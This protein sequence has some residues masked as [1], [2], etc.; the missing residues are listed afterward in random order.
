MC[1]IIA[2]K[3]DKKASEILLKGIKKLEYRG[4]DS[5]GIA[6]VKNKEISLKKDVGFTS[7]PLS[8]LCLYQLIS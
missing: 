5:V 3:G 1:G 4:Y 6:T 7:V 2:Y 8:F